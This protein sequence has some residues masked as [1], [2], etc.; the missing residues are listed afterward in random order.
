MQPIEQ[1]A[2]EFAGNN[3]D[4]FLEL[5]HDAELEDSNASALFAFGQG[6]IPTHRVILLKSIHA[7]CRGTSQL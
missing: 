6:R 3:F 7:S 4:K 2:D 1:G 5:K